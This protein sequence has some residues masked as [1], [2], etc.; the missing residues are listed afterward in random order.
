M[1]ADK[2]ILIF[3]ALFA[4]AGG[5]DRIFGNRFGL[6]KEFEKAIQ[7]MG[8]LFLTMSG[9]LVLAPFIAE[10]ISPIIIPVYGFLG[11]DPAIFAGSFLAC[12]MGGYS[13]ASELSENS[14]AIRLGGI[15]VS[16]MLGSTITFTIPVAMGV[17]QKVDRK[18]AAKG[19]L[20]GTVTI[21]A[22]VFVG[23]LIAGC[24]PLYVIKNMI[25]IIILAL[26]IAIGLWKFEKI[27]LIAFSGFG[28]FMTALSTVG[29]IIAIIQRSCG[30]TIISSL[31]PLDGVFIIIGDIAIVLAGAFPLMFIVKKILRRPLLR[32]SERIRV[33]EVSVS[34]LLTTLIN[35]IPVF[36]SVKNMDERGK[37]INMA[38]AVSGA[39]VFGDHLAFTAGVD[40]QGIIALI[41]SKLT[42]GIC[43]L[44][45]AMLVT[46][47]TTPEKEQINV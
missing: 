17:V 36:D 42:A 29:L 38:F 7:L 27:L 44:L 18:T 35:S 41:A 15:I 14:D 13:L 16:S 46:R 2:I 4:V 39:F 1:G 6:G 45:V 3:L 12:D 20:C 8:P 23:G 22:G 11:A 32:L 30:I 40:P 37:V 26:L 25:L 33:N 34:S 10:L 21:P 31:A 9:M 47:K 28:G 43:A 24:S 19:L 5:I